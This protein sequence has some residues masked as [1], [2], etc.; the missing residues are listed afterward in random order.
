M[1]EKTLAAM[2]QR[3][4]G[5]ALDIGLGFGVVIGCAAGVWSPPQGVAGAATVGAGWAAHAVWRFWKTRG[6]S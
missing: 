1:D 3:A 5:V 6:E 2:R 4:L